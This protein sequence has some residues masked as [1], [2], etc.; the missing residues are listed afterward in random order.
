MGWDLTTAI[1]VVRRKALPSQGRLKRNIFRVCRWL[2]LRLTV[3]LRG[4][5]REEMASEKAHRCPLQVLLSSPINPDRSLLGDDLDHS[6][7]RHWKDLAV[8][9]SLIG[10]SKVVGVR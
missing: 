5:L 2:S 3:L 8:R 7:V 10:K 4:L 6:C 9:K 1:V